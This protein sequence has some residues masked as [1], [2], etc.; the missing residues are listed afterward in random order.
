MMSGANMQDE[1][2]DPL[3]FS[4]LLLTIIGVLF[5]IVGA[6]DMLDTSTNL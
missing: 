2:P 1:D 4:G 6:L 5:L 3:F